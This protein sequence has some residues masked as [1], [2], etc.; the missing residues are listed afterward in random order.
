MKRE[1]GEPLFETEETKSQLSSRPMR[2]P[3]R[4]HREGET[5]ARGLFRLPLYDYSHVSRTC[6][7]PCDACSGNPSAWLQ[8]LS[9]LVVLQASERP[10]RLGSQVGSSSDARLRRACAR[11]L[12]RVPCRVPNKVVAVKKLVVGFLPRM[13]GPPSGRAP[14]SAWASS[15]RTY[16]HLTVWCCIQDFLL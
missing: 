11:H 7:V 1:P 4:H 12:S 9:V 14:G 13:T 5:S 16:L 6:I 10:A 2:L 8:S 3:L 15:W